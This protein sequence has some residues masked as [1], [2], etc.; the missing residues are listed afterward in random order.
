M[1]AGRPAAR[2]AP[3]ACTGSPWPPVHRPTAAGSTSSHDLPESAWISFVVRGGELVQVT[4]R[5]VLRDGDEALVLGAPD[6]AG[7]LREVFEG[8][9][10]FSG[11]EPISPAGAASGRIV[12]GGGEYSFAVTSSSRSGLA[13][14]RRHR[15]VSGNGRRRRRPPDRHRL[16]RTVWT[17]RPLPGGSPSASPRPCCSS[18]SSSWAGGPTS[19][20]ARRSASPWPSTSAWRSSSA[21]GS[22]STTGTTTAP[23]S[24]RGG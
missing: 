22:G 14:T 3:T 10:R 6:D 18:T 23:S 20:P 7:L 5:T 21:P 17:S 24:S 19:P 13:P 16:R 8:P 11:V 2:R 1:G 12:R 15:S 9:A 4:P